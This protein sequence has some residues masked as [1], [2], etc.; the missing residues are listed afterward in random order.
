MYTTRNER[1]QDEAEKWTT[2][3]HNNDQKAT[4]TTASANAD[5]HNDGNNYNTADN[6]C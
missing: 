5:N 4:R 2:Y 1:N 6:K 3:M